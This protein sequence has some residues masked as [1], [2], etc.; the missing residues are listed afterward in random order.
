MGSGRDFIS[1]EA[2]EKL[3]LT[4]TILESRQIVTIN[5][6]KKQST[7]IC[8]VRLDSLDDRASEQLEITG[9]KMSDN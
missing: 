1:R 6:V 3:S 8:D 4:P 2:I 7:H 9:S 5:G